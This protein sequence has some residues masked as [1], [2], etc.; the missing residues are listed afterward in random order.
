MNND[1]WLRTKPMIVVV[2]LACVVAAGILLQAHSMAALSTNGTSVAPKWTQSVPAD[3]CPNTSDTNCH[4]ASPVLA[5]LNADGKLDIVVATNNGYVVA[6]RHDGQK[7]WQRDIAPWFGMN[8]G[9]Q[10]I[11]SSPAVADI[12]GDGRLEIAVG[13]GSKFP[14]VCTQGGVVVLEHD[15]TLKP[16][17]PFLT[18]ETDLQPAGCRETVFGTPALGDLDKDG[19]LEVVFGAWDKRVYAVRHNGV[20]VPGF[21]FASA[22]YARFGWD[23]LKD[24]LADTIWS[25][26]ALA[27]LDGDGYLDIVIGADEG[28]FDDRWAPPAGWSCPYTPVGTPGYCGGSIYAVN[29]HGQPM[30]GFP[31]YKL[32]II[33]ST[34][35]LADVDGDGRAEIFVGTG[36][37]HHL[38][39]PDS[40]THGYRVFGMDQNGADLPGWQGGKQVGGN[41]LSSP[42]VGD[43]TGDGQPEVIVAAR[44]KKLYAWHVNGTAVNGFPM[45]PKTHFGQTL[46]GYTVPKSAVLGDYDGDGKQEIFMVSAWDV[47]VIDG[48]GQHLTATST[49]DSRP[50]FGTN[51]TLS[52]TPALGDLDG[53]GRLDLVASNSQVFVWELSNSTAVAE[54]PM[55]KRNAAR[56]SAVVKPVLKVEP[57]EITILHESGRNRQYATSLTLEVVNASGYRWQLSSTNADV[58][59]SPSSGNGS[60]RVQVTVTAA[61]GTNLNPGAYA[62]AEI[63]ANVTVDGRAITGS[64]ARIPLDVRVVEDLRENYLP[65]VMD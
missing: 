64:P 17:W 19:R 2:M 29:R 23:N 25:S 41:V 26:P 33:Q 39:S 32:E 49:G 9:K 27:D 18:Y 8:A 16:G 30:P 22:L 31:R 42:I 4:T 46:D 63:I 57:D 5:D 53:N 3:A 51:G 21:P 36:E 13:A 59:I 7:L 12:D 14:G 6:F 50:Y 44:D 20:R 54:W 62:L 11:H 60:G 61:V 40:P 24:R 56:T 45:T 34:P 10:E 37:F 43:I 15:G 58:T 1:T 47:V 38:T 65:M 52:N 28:N 48:N 55:F 35:A